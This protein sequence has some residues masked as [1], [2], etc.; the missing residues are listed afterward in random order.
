MVLS[1]RANCFIVKPGAEFQFAPCKGNSAV[2]VE[3]DEAG[4]VWQDNPSLVSS[5]EVKDG[6]I[7]VKL[8]SG[9]EGNA[10]VCALD[11]N[12]DTTWSWNLWVCKEDIKTVAL[13]NEAGAA[14]FLDRNIGALSATDVN[15]KAV[16]NYYQWGR[17]DAFPGQ[18]FDT[19][20]AATKAIYNMEG[21]EI[22]VNVFKITEPVLNNIPNAIAHPMTTYWMAKQAGVI[23]GNYG[24]ITTMWN[25]EEA[26][27]LKI[28]TLWNNAGKKT[29]YDP[30]PA[31]YRVADAAAW[32]VVKAFESTE[33]A[34]TTTIVDK[35]Y[36]PDAS[37]TDTWDER[38]YTKYQY[39]AYFRGGKYAGL[40]L[41]A[42]GDRTH[43]GASDGVVPTAKASTI[44]I[45]TAGTDNLTGS[46]SS[47]F[48]AFAAK[49]TPTFV[50][51]VEAV[52]A[53]PENGIEGSPAIPPYVKL[54]ALSLKS[55]LNFGYQCPVRCIKETVV[56]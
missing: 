27:A 16:G 29:V 13:S 30:C 22:K 2:N 39:Q 32:A 4:L 53:D 21:Q 1:E 20:A 33:P 54:G 23:D 19:K 11:E 6:K 18:V 5:V 48:R 38:Y 49:A 34:D 50:K 41:Y 55:G 37:V 17:K 12:K 14:E 10:V 44:T 40:V 7:S 3:A 46:S 51:A 56:E 24:W 45:W 25:S 15:G 26:V 28:D 35:S 47:Y 8:A 9:Q 31:G 43:Q 36:T 42:G 52:P